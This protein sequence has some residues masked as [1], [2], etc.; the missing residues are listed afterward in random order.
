MSDWREAEADVDFLS[1]SKAAL[2]AAE[3]DFLPF[4]DE[5]VDGDDPFVSP[6][7]GF[8][9]SFSGGV[10]LTLADDDDDPAVGLLSVFSSLFGSCLI[11]GAGSGITAGFGT[12]LPRPS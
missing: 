2:T 11:S 7:A 10:G 5:L 8:F 3:D 12:V 1:S 9:S 4:P 6:C